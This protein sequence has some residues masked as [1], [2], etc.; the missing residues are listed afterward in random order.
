MAVPFCFLSQLQPPHWERQALLFR[1]EL[2]IGKAVAC[3]GERH[4]T[5]IPSE[6][7]R[8]RTGSV[9]AKSQ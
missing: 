3:F 9:A 8:R 4:N 5:I 7:A 6:R 2:G 1:A